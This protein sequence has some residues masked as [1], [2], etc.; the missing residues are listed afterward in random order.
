MI[1][2]PDFKGPINK[3][4]SEISGELRSMDDTG[5][6]VLD[7]MNF[8]N[9]INAELKETENQSKYPFLDFLKDKSNMSDIKKV[10]STGKKTSSWQKRREI[11]KYLKDKNEIDDFLR[12]YQNYFSEK[13]KKQKKQL[14]VV[15]LVNTQLCLVV[16]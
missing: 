4:F 14:Q 7:A 1:P 11:K 8:K 16:K 6:N 13:K 9:M 10:L 15:D 12:S 3:A 5:K 2:K